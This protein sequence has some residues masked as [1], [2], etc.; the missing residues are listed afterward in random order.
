MDLK[1]ER[2]SWRSGSGRA[3]AD[4]PW[5]S[6]YRYTPGQMAS[7]RGHGKRGRWRSGSGWAP[8]NAPW[9]SSYR[10]TPGGTVACRLAVA[11]DVAANDG[12]CAPNAVV[13]CHVHSIR[14]HINFICTYLTY[15]ALLTPGTFFFS[16]HRR[17]GRAMHHQGHSA[18]PFLPQLTGQDTTGP[19][20][21]QR[22]RP[23]RPRPRA[24]HVVPNMHRRHREGEH[25]PREQM[26]HLFNGPRACLLHSLPHLRSFFEPY[27]VDIFIIVALD[28]RRW[29]IRANGTPN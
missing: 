12:L 10:Y 22:I 13:A 9:P 5:P 2:G 6:S 23:S 26:Q 20:R 11:R 8:A 29:I 17:D 16:R 4:A 7:R 25:A 18:R 1:M 19:D 15:S 28:I 14:L 3:P 27:A 24:R 21:R